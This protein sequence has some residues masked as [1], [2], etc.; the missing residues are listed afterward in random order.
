ME[1]AQ[2]VKNQQNELSTFFYVNI[3]NPHRI[4]R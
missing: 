4:V 1:T 3:K 2:S